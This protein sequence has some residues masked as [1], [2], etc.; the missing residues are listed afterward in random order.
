MLR[1]DCFAVD[2]AT[3]QATAIDLGVISAI[4]PEEQEVSAQF[5]APCGICK[6]A[7]EVTYDYADLNETA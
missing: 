4:D 6:A 1:L 7:R 2:T 3:F 5:S